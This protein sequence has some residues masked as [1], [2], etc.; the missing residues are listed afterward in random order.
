MLDS[1]SRGKSKNGMF[2]FMQYIYIYIYIY[3]CTFG[4]LD[5]YR[6][7]QAEMCYKCNQIYLS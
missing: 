1:N 5:M 4:K 2:I 3:V 6:K 7:T